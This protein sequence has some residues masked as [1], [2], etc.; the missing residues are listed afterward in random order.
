[1]KM[2]K[3]NANAVPEVKRSKGAIVLASALVLGAAAVGDASA[4]SVIDTTMKTAMET[5]FTD[6]KDTVIDVV[7]TAWPYMLG[8]TVILAAPG[9]VMGL[10]RR[11]TGR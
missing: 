8:V 10:I 6:L 1:M 7:A 11:A 2:H 9:L 3:Q 4:A 5:G